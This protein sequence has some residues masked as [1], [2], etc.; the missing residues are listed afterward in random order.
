MIASMGRRSCRPGG[1]VFV[2]EQAVVQVVENRADIKGRVLSVAR[3]AERPD[4]RLV[5]IEVSGVFPVEGYANLFASASGTRL[6]VTVPASQADALQVGANVDW[7]RFGAL[8]L[9]LGGGR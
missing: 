7:S 4:H 9:P 6:D 5:A 1:A 3:I 8:L 2:T